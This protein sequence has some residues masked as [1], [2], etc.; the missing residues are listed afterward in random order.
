MIRSTLAEQFGT[1]NDTHWKTIVLE[2]HPGS[3]TAAE[4][5][6]DVFGDGSVHPTEDVHLHQIE[7]GD[8]VKISVDDLEGRFWSFHSTSPNEDLQRAIHARVSARH[9]LDYVWLPS[10][11]LRHAL[12]G[13]PPS[14]VRADF[15][16][17]NTYPADDVQDVSIS[18]RGE[19]PDAWIR[20]VTD[21]S[22]YPHALSVTRAEFPLEHADFG[23][24]TQAIDRRAHFVARGDSF[25]LHQRVVADVVKRYRAFVEAVEERACR[26]SALPAGGGTLQG[27]PIEI[28]FS[29]PQ[30]LPLLFEELFASRDPFRLWGL[31]SVDESYGECDAVDLHVFS[32][33]RIEAQPEF[34]RVRLHAGACGNT[35]ARLV[36]NLQQRVDGALRIVDPDLQALL[37]PATDV[38]ADG[39]VLSRS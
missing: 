16:G 9:D 36:S 30:N 14:R 13:S 15:K 31:E 33:L 2:A 35:V 5:L 3:S 4:Y 32:C 38:A 6:A 21:A 18:V 28:A 24:V 7:L 10:E 39:A 29:K 26:F 12:P 17:S 8:K 37:S 23:S 1:P 27:S 11:H 20:A 34:L 19:D 22:G 25:A